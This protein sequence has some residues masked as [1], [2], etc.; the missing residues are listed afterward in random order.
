MSVRERS[1]FHTMTSNAVVNEFVALEILEKNADDAHARAQRLGPSN[2]ALKAKATLIEEES[3][4]NGE[5]EEDLRT[6]EEIKYDFNEFMALQTRAFWNKNKG[7][8]PRDNSRFTSSATRPSGAKVR[9]CYN[10]G[11]TTI[12]LWIA[13]MRERKIMVE[14]LFAKIEQSSLQART[15]TST[16]R[17]RT[18]TTRKV[19]KRRSMCLCIMRSGTPM[20]MMMMKKKV[21]PP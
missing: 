10:C 12:S 18:S 6:N 21:K 3:V 20:E 11:K 16:T 5:E 14:D 8:R 13:H 7:S 1:D 19:N 9:V 4:E 15:R 17:T 2:L